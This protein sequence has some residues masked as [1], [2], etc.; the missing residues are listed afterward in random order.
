M[1]NQL[2][3]FDN[4]ADFY[5][6]D[7]TNFNQGDSTFKVHASLIY[8]LGESLIADEVTA[9]SELIKNSYDADAKFCVLSIDT[10]YEEEIDGIVCQGKI[11]LID[12][13]CGMNLETIV[14]GWLTL[15]N[16]PKKKMKKE[17]KTTPKYKRYPLG[18]KGLGRLSVQK[19]GRYMQMVTKSEDSEVEYTVVIPWGDFLKNTTIDQIPVKITQNQMDN[20]KS[21]TK[22][23]I[24]DLVNVDLWSSESQINVLSN[25]INKIVSPF[26]SKGNTFRVSASIDGVPIEPIDNI[27]NDLL[28]RA[29]ARHTISYKAGKSDIRSYITN[30]FFYNRDLMKSISR[31]QFSLNTSALDDFWNVYKSKLPMFS[32][33]REEKNVFTSIDEY[34]FEDLLYDSNFEVQN[35]NDPGPFECE[36]YE[37]TLDQDFLDNYYDLISFSDLI[38]QTEYRMFIDRFHGVKVVR[39]GFIVQGYGEGD[40]GD[41]LGLSA[42][43]KTT[44]R[45]FD[46]RNDSVIGCVYI[47]G[48]DNYSLKETTNRE[49]F[50][51][52]SHFETFKRILTESIKRINRNRNKLNSS[53]RSYVVDS[54]LT[55]SENTTIDDAFNNAINNIQIKMDAAEKANNDL[56][57]A[58]ENANNNC[59]YVQESL[60]TLPFVDSELVSTVN[61]LS[62]NTSIISAQYSELL[63]TFQYLDNQLNSV[64]YDFEKINER[65]RDLFELAGLGISV[66]MFTHEFDSSV[67]NIRL[68]NNAIINRE[69][70]NANEEL[71]K[72]LQYISYAL[73]I[74]RK[75]MSYFNPGLKFVRSEKQTI[76]FSDFILEHKEFYS[77]RCKNESIQYLATMRNDFSFKANRGM[78]NQVLDNLFNNSEYWLDFS[79]NKG[80]INEKV[81]SVCCQEK[82]I[83]IVSDNGIG[84]SKDIENTLF[85]PFESKKENGR[86]LGLYIVSNN[87]KYHNARIRLLGERNTF[88]N[89]YKFEID[90]T[91]L[92]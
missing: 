50:V 33:N 86:G 18:D 72:H 34:L 55:S 16:S 63:N 67:K 35:E 40:G 14:N 44:G 57:N 56:S 32:F 81:F 46:L 36:I 4:N 79:K 19:L 43:S 70:G 7:V 76:N 59:K 51:E 47:S 21:Y 71:I 11:E 38:D 39:D 20:D 60:E 91:A 92:L 31:N 62:K 24:K 58:I 30:S 52:D 25:S 54:V 26:K 28:L 66:E 89:L 2:N 3:L 27:F 9:L 73:D 42:S 68:K 22:I 75:Q 49:G 13:G 12:N 82:G 48:K 69:T 8:K 23:I 53:M 37:Y 10:K 65:L 90:L 61:A 17:K 6:A 85:E 29:R 87:L 88:G 83:F 5:Q 80:L 84:I 41:W 1:P 78:M 77:E 45:Y 74:L 15:S 64:S